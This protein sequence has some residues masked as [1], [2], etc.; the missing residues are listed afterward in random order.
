MD[1]SSADRRPL[2]WAADQSRQAADERERL[3]DQREQAADERDR[4]ADESRRAADQREQAA[5]ERERAAD[6]RE[7]A[8]DQREAR[9]DDREHRLDARS[10]SVRRGM[11]ALLDSVEETVKRGR[12]ILDRQSRRLDRLEAGGALDQARA[13]REQAEIDWES[14]GAPPRPG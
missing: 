5:D 14:G 12:E 8:A 9:L 7:Q 3:A 10:H 11:P 2:E 13:Q 4:A 1:D 6:E